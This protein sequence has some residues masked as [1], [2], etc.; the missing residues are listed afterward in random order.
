MLSIKA[1]GS[2]ADIVKHAQDV[3]GRIVP[4]AAST[5][6]TRTAHI[7]RKDTIPKQMQRDFFQPSRYTLNALFVQRASK[8]NLIARIAVKN[9]GRKVPQENPLLP[10]VRG[11]GRKAKGFDMWLRREGYMRPDEF[12][13]PT[14]VLSPKQYESGGWIRRLM[15]RIEAPYVGGRRKR[16]FAGRVTV[17]GT[18]K[19]GIW[20]A[21]GK[22]RKGRKIQPL[23]VFT[24]QPKYQAI[25]KF[26]AVAKKT[27]EQHFQQEF[28]KALKQLEPKFT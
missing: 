9:K 2:I 5:A 1:S 16:V 10:N 28:A 24:K 27:A 17:G 15:K 26:E 11:G 13:I 25:F 4:Y 23:F 19:R 18:D 12:A 14:R 22:G 8:D 6:L 7:A 20:E 21:W 3:H